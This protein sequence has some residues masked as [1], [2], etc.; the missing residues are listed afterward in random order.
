MGKLPVTG[1]PAALSVPAHRRAGSLRTSI[2]WLVLACLL[3]LILLA[4][5]L[6]RQ[7]Y[8]LAQERLHSQ[9]LLIARNISARL[10]RELTAIE[11]G[12]KVLATSEYLAAGDLRR[13][14]QQARDAVRS[15]IVYNYILTD[16]DG[17]QLLNT[18]RPYGT[19]LPKTG[20][21][22]A[23]SAVFQQRKTVLTDLF[24]GPV[25][26]RPVLAM[27]VPVEING[28][29]R[30]SL[31]IGLD[32]K[33][34]E[35]LLRDESLSDQWLAVILDSSATIVAR[36]RSP[37]KFVG[38]KAV[39][40]VANRMLADDEATF[41]T[42]TKEGTP[43][44]SSHHRSRTWGW[45]A[46]VGAHR[47]ILDAELNR[48]LRW[49]L[50]GFA[51]AALVGWSL[52]LLISQR[53]VHHL[54]KLNAAAR[55]ISQ[56]TAQGELEGG[57]RETEAI[58]EALNLA[59]TAMTESRHR[60]SHDALTGLAN[61]ALFDELA[62]SQL[63]RSRREG[64]GHAILAMDLD[65]FK[66]VN[67]SC[68]HAVGDAVLCEV[69]RRTQASVRD[70]DLVA[71]LGGDEFLV[72]LSNADGA[73]AQEVA[74]RLIGALSEPYDGT[75]IAVSASI[76]IALYPDHGESN[77]QLLQRA[78]LALYAAKRNGRRRAVVW[79]PE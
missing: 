78:D 73:L 45:I 79:Q 6:A 43:V 77:A 49:L 12:L 3:P 38:Q 29:V 14:H 32:P 57:F 51:V 55:S 66:Q 61:R 56:G 19:A 41:E 4:G 54:Q 46:A 11:S 68:G 34:L 7:N 65:H 44:I 37:E 60:A 53:I 16:A 22:P 24:E 48:S 40:E 76:G 35:P 75:S 26:R 27:G 5:Y 67:D 63:S 69:A 9:S 21:P 17:R 74:N 23:L 64:G 33:A 30:Y 50:L 39:P 1:G 62:Q 10:D 71:R 52:A 8:V 42:V 72:L 20:T 13:F 58:A 36:T 70:F 59:A 47:E 28:T 18:V 15:Q 2:L 25:V 31:N